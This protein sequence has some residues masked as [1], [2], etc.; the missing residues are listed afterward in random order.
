MN[1]QDERAVWK[2][3]YGALIG[4]DWA[5]EEHVYHLTESMTGESETATLL[6]RPESLDEWAAE[7]SAR[8]DK[9]VAVCLE[10]KK[11]PLVAGL[12]KHDFIEL[13]PLNPKKLK[14]YRQA[15]TTSGAVDDPTDALSLW[16]YLD[17]FG[18]RMKAWKPDTVETRLLGELTEDR[19]HEVEEIKRHTNEL[20]A[21]L[22]RYFPLALDVLCHLNTAMACDFLE[23]WPANEKLRRAQPKTLQKFYTGHGCRDQTLIEER[24]KTIKSARPLT[25]DRALVES[26]ALRVQ[27]LACQ[28]RVLIESVNAYDEKIAEV[29]S[30]HPEADFYSNLPAAGNALAPRLLAAMGTDRERWESAKEIQVFH[31]TAPVTEKSGKNKHWVHWRWACPKFLRQTWHEFADHS[32]KKSDWARAFYQMKRDEGKGH[33]HTLRALACKW[34]RVLYA[35]WKNRTQYDETQYIE[36]LNKRGSKIINYMSKNGE[37]D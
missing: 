26:G 28:I 29:M 24:I 34:I 1:W 37:K 32:R 33:H 20:R 14:E 15:F 23:K 18:H 25:T 9:P 6:Q 4:I 7:L 12:M 22:K 17:T 2:R 27:K 30:E 11:G 5:D 19:R 8:L 10:Q 35:C 21:R 3:Q 16:S 13:Y 31:G 36:A